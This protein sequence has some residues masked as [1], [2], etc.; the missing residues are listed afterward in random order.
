MVSPIQR[1]V[2]CFSL[3]HRSKIDEQSYTSNNHELG[4]LLF[5]CPHVQPSHALPDRLH[6]NMKGKMV[7]CNRPENVH[8]LRR[9]SWHVRD[10]VWISHIR[11]G[12]NTCR[13]DTRTLLL[14]HWEVHMWPANCWIQSGTVVPRHRLGIDTSLG[15]ADHVA[16]IGHM[17]QR[18]R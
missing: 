3:L 1:Y 17:A 9:C 16:A 6:F 13:V 12:G 2:M 18:S 7:L 4:C 15:H 11:W 8:D 10:C 5:M 14:I